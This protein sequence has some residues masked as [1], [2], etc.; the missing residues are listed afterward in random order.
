MHA[1]ISWSPPNPCPR[2]HTRHKLLSYQIELTV[3]FESRPL[4]SFRGPSGT[5]TGV[6]FLSATLASPY[7]NSKTR[8]ENVG[9]NHP[10]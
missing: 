3:I 1:C 6:T 7:G 8:H 5:L 9:C 2:R 4:D 10:T